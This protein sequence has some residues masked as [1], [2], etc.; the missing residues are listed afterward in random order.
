MPLPHPPRVSPRLPAPPAAPSR[1]CLKMKPTTLLLALATSSVSFAT[2]VWVDPATGDDTN[3]GTET[4]PFRTIGH[5]AAQGSVTVHL[6]AGDYSSATGEVFPIEL[7]DGDAL[8]GVAGR[9]QT[10]VMLPSDNAGAT[11]GVEFRGSVAIE[12]V[13][14]EQPGAA[15]TALG[16]PISFSPPS[17]TAQLEL[18]DTRFVGGAVGFVAFAISVSMED[19]EFQGQAEEAVRVHVAF[20]TLSDVVIRDVNRGINVDMW[21]GLDV[22]L[23]IERTSILNAANEAIRLANWSSHGNQLRFTLHDCLIAGHAVGIRDESFSFAPVLM[24]QGCTVVSDRGVGLDA[25]ASLTGCIVAGH[26]DGD[27]VEPSSLSHCLI[28][29]GL[30]PHADATN[31]S[32]DPQFVDRAGGDYRLG[33]GSPCVDTGLTLTGRD[34]L[35]RPR[36]V[37]GDLQLDP[38]P[39]MGALEHQTLTGPASVALGAPIPLELTGPAGGFST[40]VISP[41]G[42]APIGATTPFGRL[43]LDASSAFRLTPVATHGAA[44]TLLDAP[45]FTDPALVGTQVGLQA[46][47]R[48]ANAPAGGAFSQPILVRIDA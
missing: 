19:C 26:P 22:G 33:W 13:T 18:R 36:V 25:S 8:I 23:T 40:V 10:R 2:D 48:S 47:T 31:R 24:L 14:L 1:P 20:G 4:L 35:G 45:A 5:A 7:G 27:L 32:G 11:A 15:A 30:G 21:D 43:F 12:G 6:A 41:T 39:D 3:P 44:P 17:W 38:A 46:L 16:T 34:V 29:D 37:D 9:D 42:Y 28:E